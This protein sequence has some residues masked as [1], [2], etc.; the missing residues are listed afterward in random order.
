MGRAAELPLLECARFLSRFVGAARWVRISGESGPVFGHKG[1]EG[2]NRVHGG[3]AGK[4]PCFPSVPWANRVGFVPFVCL[5]VPSLAR[6]NVESREA[7]DPTG[8]GRSTFK[9]LG[10]RTLNALTLWR[11]YGRRRQTG[12]TALHPGYRPGRSRGVPASD[13]RDR[14]RRPA[15][16]HPRPSRLSPAGRRPATTGQCALG[17]VAALQP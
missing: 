14:S 11:G 3:R 12:G 5:V 13:Q 17:A 10:F 1:H 16:H 6:S 4:I 15:H 2:P 8:S 9:T 7:E